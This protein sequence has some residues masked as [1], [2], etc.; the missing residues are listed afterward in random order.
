MTII[1]V[2]EPFASGVAVFVKLLTEAMPDDQHIVIH[3]ERQRVKPAADV[4][5]EFPARNVRFIR[6]RSARRSIDPVRDAMAFSELVTIFRRLHRKGLVDAVHLHSSKGGLLGRAAAR[7]VGI[8]NVFYTPNGASFLSSRFKLMRFLFRRMEKLGSRLGGQVICCSPSELL[9]YRQLGIEAQYINNGIASDNIS[10][11]GLDELT[12]QFTVVTSGRIDD[13]KN[14]VLFNEIAS[15]FRDMPDVRFLW[16]GDGRHRRVLTSPNITV[17]GWKDSTEVHRI[18]AQSQVYLS[19]SRYE[20][21]SFAVLEALALRKPVLLSQC[22]GN[23]DIVR[24][25]VNGDLFKSPYD[26]IV[27]LLHYYNNP[28]MLEVMGAYSGAICKADYNMR[29]NFKGYR[30]LY[31]GTWKA[32]K[33]SVM[34]W[35]PEFSREKISTSSI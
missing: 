35:L 28:E 21:L 19:T 20:G 27:K 22:T 11:D 1:H 23:V 26:A 29:E 8:Q 16:I 34:S 15:Y 32:A 10:A 5:K 13:Q 18:V 17:T 4:K 3:G 24:L 33:T 30:E 9:A 25:G 6:W 12:S 14:P 7:V 2:V 31:A